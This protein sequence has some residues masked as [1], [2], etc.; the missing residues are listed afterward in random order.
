[1]G[2]IC[3]VRGKALGTRFTDDFNRADSAA[4]GGPF[5]ELT[6]GGTVG[7]PLA[8]I[9]NAAALT[10]GTGQGSAT[11]D[12]TTTN[13][14]VEADVILGTDELALSLGHAAGIADSASVHIRIARL[15]AST[16]TVT[17]KQH[18]AVG[19]VMSGNGVETALANY[20]QASNTFTMRVNK[21]GT[22]YE[23]YFNGVLHATT[24]STY[25]SGGPRCGIA[26]R[27]TNKVD[28]LMV[29]SL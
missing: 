29:G 17:L 8:I 25:G 12:T 24:T 10:G 7:T 13:H 9:T 18:D 16:V 21:I 28:R 14:Y 22:T 6:T 27:G 19:S 2:S 5:E 1:M 3:V 26:M 15:D 4:L 20:A 23:V 11:K